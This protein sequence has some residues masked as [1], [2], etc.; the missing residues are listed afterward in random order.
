MG[1]Y[2]GDRLPPKAYPAE[3]SNLSNPRHI[4]PGERTHPF[5]RRIDAVLNLQQWMMQN[6]CEFATDYPAL[7]RTLA[8]PL[9]LRASE[10]IIQFPFSTPAAEEKT[11]EELARIAE[12]KREQGRK[13]QEIAAKARMEKVIPQFIPDCPSFANGRLWHVARTEGKRPT[14]HAESTRAER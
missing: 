5:P 7:L 11:E 9:H 14:A 1:S 3:I 6:F 2:T 13:L 4:L 8:D 12:R 10:R